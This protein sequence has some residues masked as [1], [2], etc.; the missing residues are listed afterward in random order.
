MCKDDS[1][2]IRHV[3]PPSACRPSD[4]LGRYQTR[5]L[6]VAK[7]ITTTGWQIACCTA[8]FWLCQPGRLRPQESFSTDPAS[9]ALRFMSAPK[10]W[11]NRPALLWI[12]EGFWVLRFR[13]MVKRGH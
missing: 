11:G 7:D 8:E 5:P 13:L 6:L 3:E 2:F 4:N 10:R 12:A 1:W 9:L